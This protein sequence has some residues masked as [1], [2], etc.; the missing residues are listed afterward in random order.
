[1]KIGLIG[2]GDIAEKA[3]LPTVCAMPGMEIHLCTRNQERLES[4][5]RQYRIHHLHGTVSELVNSG[6]EAVFVH[7]ATE[8]HPVL[9]AS[10]L[11]AGV[12]TFVDKPV[13]YHL[14]DVEALFAQS[15]RQNLLLEVGFNRRFAPAYAALQ[16]MHNKDIVVLEKNR[17]SQPAAVRTVV[18]DDFIHVVDTLRIL[19]PGPVQVVQL[20]G[21]VRGGQLQ[22]VTLELA[23]GATTAIGIM[24]RNTGF[25]EERLEVVT[26]GKKIVVTNL[27][28]VEEFRE[29]AIRPAAD[30]WTSTVARR[31]FPQMVGRF[32][33]WVQVFN[34]A[35]DKAET[36]SLAQHAQDMLETH[37]IC[38]TIVS[39]LESQST[40]ERP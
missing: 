4:L 31:G 21:R 33:E 2:L 1:M 12:H 5:G 15:L 20:Q 23:N 16:R 34:A 35:G 40:Y 18:M 29:T 24:H 14:D 11:D 3:Y 19:M 26:E 7:A 38:D 25:T 36:V 22:Y 17:Q 32:L 30:N 37:R 27:T 39:Q 6:V 10:L 13:A 28:D 8:A 9:V